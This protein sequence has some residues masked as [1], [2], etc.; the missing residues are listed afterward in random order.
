MNEAFSRGDDP[1]RWIEDYN[2]SAAESTS[3][4]TKFMIVAFFSGS[5]PKRFSPQDQ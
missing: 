2:K 3:A 1:S 4:V 5:K